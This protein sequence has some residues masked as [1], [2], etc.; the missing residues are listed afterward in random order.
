MTEDS[1]TK[2]ANEIVNELI[3]YNKIKMSV[4]NIWAEKIID[5]LLN[6]KT[7]Y[8]LFQHS[9]IMKGIPSIPADEGIAQ[10]LEMFT[11]VNSVPEENMLEDHSNQLPP[12]EQWKVDFNYMNFAQ[13]KDKVAGWLRCGC[14]EKSIPNFVMEWVREL[15]DESLIMVMREYFREGRDKWCGITEVSDAVKKI[16]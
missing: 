6:E 8:N 12:R 14:P 11:N 1:V 7:D 9:K 2:R 3:V 10:L 13:Q 5:F 15:E 4:K 16:K